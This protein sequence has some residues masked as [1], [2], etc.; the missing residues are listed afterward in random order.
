MCTETCGRTTPPDVP[1]LIEAF[2]A[3]ARDAF[4]FLEEAHGLRAGGVA[5]Y[6]VDDAGRTPADAST[7]TYPF[8]AMVEFTGAGRPTRLSYG[9]RDYS[10]DLELGAN[11]SG[12]HSI[13]S[14]LDA[15]GIDEPEVDDSGVAT[16]DALDRHTRRLAGLLRDHFDAIRTAGPEVVGRLP[17]LGA[18]T[19]PR[20][21]RTRD[22]AHAAFSE[23]DY[24]SYI[25]LLAP[26]EAA[27]T[28]TERRKLDFARARS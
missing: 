14:W 20:L 8:V 9:R 28:V 18:R 16:P 13:G 21:N 22:K 15:L 26:F 19:A 1:E 10:L 6:A 2:R 24:A 5:I 23:G 12:F 11:G 3:V 25:E 7:V 4:G 27:L 17:S